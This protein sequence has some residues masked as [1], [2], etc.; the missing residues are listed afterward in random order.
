MIFPNVHTEQHVRAFQGLKRVIGE[1][2]EAE[3][4]VPNDELTSSF[5]LSLFCMIRVLQ[6]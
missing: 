5:L 3:G 1:E 2:I 4:T 6:F